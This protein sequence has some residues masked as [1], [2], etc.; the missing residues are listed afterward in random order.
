M[1]LS[2]WFYVGVESL[3]LANAYNTEVNN[4]EAFH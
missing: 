1:P 2:T 3:N 4:K